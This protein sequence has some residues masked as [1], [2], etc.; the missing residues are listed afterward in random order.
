[1]RGRP[2]KTKEQIAAA[3]KQKPYCPYCDNSKMLKEMVAGKRRGFCRKCWQKYMRQYREEHK[4][5]IREIARESY[6]RRKDI[7]TNN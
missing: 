5:R 6:H 3:N 4:E 7:D 2:R 1:M